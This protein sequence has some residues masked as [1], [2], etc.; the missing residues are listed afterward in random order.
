M[1]SLASLVVASA[2]V[3]AEPR[4]AEVADGSTLERVERILCPEEGGGPCAEDRLARDLARLGS[5]AIPTLFSLFTGEGLG[6]LLEGGAYGPETRERWRCKPDRVDAIALEALALLPAEDV[7]EHVTRQVGSGEDLDRRLLIVRLLGRLAS[8]E[9]VTLLIDLGADLPEATFHYRSVRDK[10]IQA[11]ASVL[12]ENQ[13]QAGSFGRELRGVHGEYVRVAIEGAVR[14]DRPRTA[15]FLFE[16]LDREEAW[17]LDAL[18]A[19]ARLEVRYPWHRFPRYQSMLVAQLGEREPDTRRR[20]ALALGELGT[21][22][23]LELL[24]PL[25]EDDDPAVRSA[26][27]WALSAATGLGHEDPAAWSRWRDEEEEWWRLRSTPCLTALEG[28][29]PAAV[30]TALRELSQRSLFRHETARTIADALLDVPPESARSACAALEHLGSRHAVPGL[31]DALKGA[32][33]A[34]EEE[35]VRVLHELT[36][37]EHGADPDAWERVLG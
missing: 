2:L 23:H 18:E 16:L 9:G 31:I 36:G 7:V 24:L 32:D 21:S 28:D 6:A 19:L 13:V 33:F 4:F 1:A 37:E 25:L 29:D 35:I 12:R 20:A 11:W 34:L 10:F 17:H 15:R 14:S 8:V 22:E 26:A 3:V 27:R 5:D 30:I